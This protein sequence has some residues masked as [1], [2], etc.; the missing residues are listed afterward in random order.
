[1]GKVIAPALASILM[2][3]DRFANTNKCGAYTGFTSR[4]KGSSGREIE[5]LKITKSGN[6]RLKRDLALAAD[7]AMKID[8]E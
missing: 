4:W 5:G 7:T 6:R 3:V 1:M 8:P 2:P